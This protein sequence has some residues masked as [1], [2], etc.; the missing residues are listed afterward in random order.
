MLK[1]LWYAAC[2]AAALGD[3]PKAVRILGHDLVLFRDA[4]GTPACLADTCV[5]RGAPLSRGRCVDGRVQCPYHG[6]VYATDGR[7]VEIPSLEPQ[8][9]LPER[10]RVDAYP[11]RVRFGLVWVFLGD[12][13]PEE[14][15][16]IAE[17]LPEF[18]ATDPPWRCIHGTFAYAAN[19]E[20]VFENHID[21][22]HTHFIHPDFGNPDDPRVPRAKVQAEGLGAWAEH[23]YQ[24]RPKRGALGALVDEHRPPVRTRLA[25]DLGG[26]C[27]R[28]AI[29]M[30]DTLRQVVF[31]AFT[32]IDEHH[33]VAHYIQAR[34]FLLE[35]EHDEP[36]RGDLEKIFTEDREILE[37]LRPVAVPHALN[38]ELS[39]QTDALP[40]AFRHQVRRWREAHGAIRS[41]DPAV[42]ITAI[43]S[44]ARRAPGH[45]VVPEARPQAGPRE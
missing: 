38:A 43:P 21:S 31:Q 23:S 8:A 40:V 34:N 44:P 41:P 16:A 24:P 29:R 7:C 22:A 39:V 42:E 28:L 10:A 30:T 35:A 11:C 2:L 9:R 45:W 12:L 3:R 15:P 5:H 20:R 18:T 4:S 27:V 19:W 6:W 36:M 26:L 37:A 25:F 33:T 1:N 17:F 14:R 13:A 32:P